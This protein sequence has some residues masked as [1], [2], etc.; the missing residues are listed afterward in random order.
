[1]LD[2]HWIQIDGV[3]YSMNAR[4]MTFSELTSTKKL[5]AL[6]YSDLVDTST[7]TC[8]LFTGLKEQW[9]PTDC[10]FVRFLSQLLLKS[11]RG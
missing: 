7:D 9:R 5:H 11:I 8:A 1:M 10:V 2:R 3:R 6:L 4:T